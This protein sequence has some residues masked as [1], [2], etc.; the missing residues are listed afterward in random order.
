VVAHLLEDIGVAGVVEVKRFLAM[1][2][3]DFV[4]GGT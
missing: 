2:T 3:L 4:H 1:R